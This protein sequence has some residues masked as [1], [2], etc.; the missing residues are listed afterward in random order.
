METLGLSH[1]DDTTTT[2][3]NG[4]DLGTDDILAQ[5][6]GNN[7][8]AT[9]SKSEEDEIDKLLA[10]ASL[11]LPERRM[12]AYTSQPSATD[13][14]DVS[15]F[16]LDEEDHDHDHDHDGDDLGPRPPHPEDK[17]ESADD[18][19]ARIKDELANAPPSPSPPPGG[20]NDDDENDPSTR[21][22]Q[23][24]LASL[25]PLP[26]TTTNPSSTTTPTLSLPSVPTSLPTLPTLP[27]V[28]TDRDNPNPNM[29]RDQFKR[30][31]EEQEAEHWCCICNADA[32]YRCSGCDGD[33]YCGECLF[34]GHTGPGVAAGAEERRHKWTRYSRGKRVAAA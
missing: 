20:D 25:S 6:I 5:W 1:N 12:G 2:G 27:S 13:T 18:I 7:Q 22:L 31:R 16:T 14:F 3:G 9:M 17:E 34:K 29:T 23:A 32:E 26:T 10:E 24:R 19:I 11:V 33:L 30:Y 15:A 8:N 28:P 21:L 4:I